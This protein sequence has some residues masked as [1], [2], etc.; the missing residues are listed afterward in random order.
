MRRWRPMLGA[1]LGDIHVIH[2]ETLDENQLMLVQEEREDE[3]EQEE[4]LEE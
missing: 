2:C 3:D 4:T 1:L